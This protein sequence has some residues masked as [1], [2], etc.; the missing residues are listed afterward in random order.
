MR[1][2]IVEDEAQ[3]AQAL[4]R[5]LRRF[6]FV[7][8]VAIDGDSGFRKATVVDYDAVV[9]DRDLPVMHGDEVCRRLNAEARRSRILMLTAAGELEEIVGGLDIG[10]D[11]YLGMCSTTGRSWAVHPPARDPSPLQ[12]G[13]APYRRLPRFGRRTTVAATRSTPRSPRRG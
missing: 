4:A 5:G 10:A 2:L 7:V 1:V 9:L 11:D 12:P 3:L 13:Q 8:D 6:G